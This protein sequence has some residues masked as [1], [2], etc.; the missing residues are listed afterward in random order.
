MSFNLGLVVAATGS[1]P[2]AAGE[3]DHTKNL[4]YKRT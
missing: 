4:Y 2:A 3:N 1:G